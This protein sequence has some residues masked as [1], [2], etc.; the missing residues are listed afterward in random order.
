[1]RDELLTIADDWRR[2]LAEDPTNAR[3]IVSSLL[4]GRVTFTPLP[5]LGWWRL[6]GDGQS[7][8]RR[9]RV[10]AGLG[11]QHAKGCHK[12]RLFPALPMMRDSIRPESDPRA[13]A[14]NWAMLEKE[15]IERGG[16]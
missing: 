6:S 1:V 12:G 9:R 8:E 2:V 7:R 10:G 11:L 15:D 5:K 4:N 3:P 16:E 14:V 13:L